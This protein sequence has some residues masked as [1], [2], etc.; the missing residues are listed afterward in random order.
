MSNRLK[1]VSV[2]KALQSLQQIK[3]GE[4]TVNGKKTLMATRPTAEQ[5]ELLQRLKVKP[6]PARFE[7]S[8]R[9]V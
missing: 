2:R 7:H 1:T 4:L 9:V 5:R 6:I 8:G 3:V